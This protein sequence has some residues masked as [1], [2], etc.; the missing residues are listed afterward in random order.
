MRLH[1]PVLA[2]GAVLALTLAACG[3]QNSGAGPAQSSTADALSARTQI[4]VVY[5]PGVVPNSLVAIADKLGFFDRE[6]L[7]LVPFA[8]QAATTSAQLLA[9]G[10][11]DFATA[12]LPNVIDTLKE[13]GLH[14]LLVT[15]TSRRQPVQILC[16]PSLGI[17][18][19]FPQTFSTLKGKTVAV[20]AAATPSDNILRYT[21]LS[22]GL[23][24]TDMQII[25]A[26]NTG[27]IN[28]AL[29][30][31][32][33]DCAYAQEPFPAQF[34]S[35]Y[36]SAVNYAGTEQPKA[37]QD[38]IF[39]PVAAG[40]TILSNRPVLRAFARAMLAA[41]T[42]ANDP[43]NAN[44]IAQALLPDFSGV[45]VEQLTKVYQSC[46]GIWTAEL[47]PQMFSNFSEIIATASGKPTSY[48]SADYVS[49][50]VQDLVS[51]PAPPAAK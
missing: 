28:S 34:G 22:A 11:V 14:V 31:G 7:E 45:T 43:G 13:Q 30:A 24:L 16:K 9:S 4:K 33:V 26:G 17:Q 6:K 46:A 20:T 5:S 2:L 50:D 35:A 1:R 42:F 23:S 37:L 48:S 39:A 12:V 41:A 36:S 51:T 15:G 3:G 29:M 25:H 49:P 10:Q 21:I 38:L 40:P 44:K 27:T 18:G 32:K 8:Q 47:T 19:T